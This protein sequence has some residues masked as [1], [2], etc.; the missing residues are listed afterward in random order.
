VDPDGLEDRLL[1]GMSGQTIVAFA[2]V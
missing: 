1:E 2:L